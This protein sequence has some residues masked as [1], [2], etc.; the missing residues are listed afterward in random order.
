MARAGSSRALGGVLIQAQRQRLC[1]RLALHVDLIRRN[2][3]RAEEHLARC[4]AAIATVE[5][6]RFVRKWYRDPEH[7]MTNRPPLGNAPRSRAGLWKPGQLDEDHGVGFHNASG[8]GMEAIR[9]SEPAAYV[10]LPLA[11]GG[12]TITLN[13]LFRPPVGDVPH[14]RFYLNERPLP[15]EDICTRQDHV[16]VHVE[17]PESSVAPRLG[18]VCT[19]HHAEGDDRALGL[20]VTSLTWI[21]EDSRT[22]T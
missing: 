2:E 7:N 1:A 15:S 13:W 8:D 20:P 6:T 17:I 22:A 16:D 11:A 19:A 18:W 3:S 21:R 5:R 12:Y 10:E 14:L 4:C 9:W